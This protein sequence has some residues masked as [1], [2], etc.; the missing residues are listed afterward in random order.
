MS[1][2]NSLLHPF[3]GDV[4]CQLKQVVDA[5]RVKAEAVFGVVEGHTD[6]RLT[7]LCNDSG[8]DLRV[9]ATGA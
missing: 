1:H 6:R 3:V 9:C 2:G 8:A 4:I 5:V 7:D